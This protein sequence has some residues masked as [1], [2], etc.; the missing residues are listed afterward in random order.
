M[1][2][3]SHYVKTCIIQLGNFVSFYNKEPLFEEI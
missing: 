1:T 2:S 3:I